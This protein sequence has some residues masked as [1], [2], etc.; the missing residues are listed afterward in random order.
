MMAEN[1]CVAIA[2]EDGGVSIMTILRADG[3]SPTAIAAEIEKWQSTSE[4]KAVDH[5]P[6]R[7]ADIPPDRAFRDAWTHRGG[8]LC[9]VDMEKARTIQMDR[10]RAARDA[11]LAALDLPFMRAV[12]AGDDAKRAEIAAA[13]QRL[14]D[15]PQTV[16]LAK[17]R[18]PD[19]LKAIWPEV[20]PR[21]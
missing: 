1:V 20:L 7:E 8:E 17:A 6:I 13:K 11:K 2:R 14:R 10:I 15:L 21:R 16:D 5:W 4:V 3:D 9:V 19:E 12:E 18:T